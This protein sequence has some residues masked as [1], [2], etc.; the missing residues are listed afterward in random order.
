MEEVRAIITVSGQLFLPTGQGIFQTVQRQ[1]I[2]MTHF[3][4]FGN[5]SQVDMVLSDPSAPPPPAF[6]R[7]IS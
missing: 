7:S 2:A 6:L 3:D 1:G 5:L 4:G